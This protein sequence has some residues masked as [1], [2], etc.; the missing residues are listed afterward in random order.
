MSAGRDMSR[1]GVIGAGYVGATTAACLAHLGHDVVCADLND[2]LIARLNQAD[3]PILEAQLPELIREGLDVGRLRFV[4]DPE[5]A[6]REAEFVFLC[7][8]TPQ[9]E[10]GEADLSY[11]EGAVATLAPVLGPG[12]IVVNKSTMP[13]GS[14]GQVKA[15]FNAHGATEVRVASNP[16]FLAEGT[17]VRE[18]LN[19]ERI[20]IGVDEEETAVRLSLLYRKLQARIIVTDPASAEMIKYASNA[21]LA[22]RISFMNSIANLCEA[23]GADVSDVAL[24]MGYDSRIGFAALKPGPGYGG[25]CLPKDTAALVNSAQ[26]VGFDFEHLQ[27]TRAVN[28]RQRRRIVEKI[29]SAV[30]GSLAGARI[31]VWGLTFKADTDDVRD[32][33][34]IDIA[35]ELVDA[36][37]VVRAYDPKAR[38]DAVLAQV[39]V[40]IADEPYAACDGAQV[41]AVLTEWDEFRWLDFGKVGE[42][43]A[44]N[45]VVDARNVLDREGLVRRGFVY[46]GVGR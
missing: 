43:M 6:G 44:V 41:L 37:A 17:A 42:V 46:E 12:T 8:N 4:T 5:E 45:T 1:V 10:S 32:S 30:G 23:V 40:E 39:D 34:A 15:W 14:A 29:E 9:G 21:Y 35:R 18:F 13:V 3:V 2:Q 36:G 24:G 27:V 28:E 25:S 31:A 20:V 33:P 19:P 16:E 22:T 7:V 26:K 11:V 38:R